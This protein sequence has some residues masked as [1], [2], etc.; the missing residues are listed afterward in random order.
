MNKILQLNPNDYPLFIALLIKLIQ[1]LTNVYTK[2]ISDYGFARAGGLSY[3]TLL[4][5]VPFA[6]LVI[7]LMSAFGA[8]DSVQEQIMDFVVRML[9]PTEQAAIKAI[10]DQFLSNSNTLGVVGLVFFTITS[11]MLLNSININLNAV[12]G[13]RVQTNFMNKFTTYASVIIFGTLLLAASTTITSR[14]SF[15]HIDNI[16]IL[17]RII[18]WIAPYIFDFFV[19]MLIIGITPSG[20]VKIKYLLIVSMIGSILWELLKYGF[21]NVSSWAIRT[22]VIYGTIAVIPIFLFWVYIIW[23]IIIFCME[24]AWVLQFKNREWQGKSLTEMT[25]SEKVTFGFELFLVA[26]EEFEA[27]RKGPTLEQLSDVFS[28]SMSEVREMTSLLEKKDLLLSAGEGGM[29]WIPARSLTQ[30]RTV[31]V[32]KA[33]FGTLSTPELDDFY[34]A[35]IEGIKHE[36]ISDLL[37]TD[38]NRRI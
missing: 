14:F 22:S 26:A 32:L 28:V 9:M 13:S 5:A 29:F 7:S 19:I 25:P 18:L 4:A 36:Y 6:A 11:I 1:L 8:L 16:K 2:F 30:I 15:L 12:W 20:R 10:L 31:D 37:S 23:L 34:Q 38:K 21:V 27:G 3:T 33:V 24:I 35:G 17:N